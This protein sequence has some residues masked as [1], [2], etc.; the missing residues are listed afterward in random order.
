MGTINDTTSS[1]GAPSPPAV[2]RRSPP[3][4]AEA[5]LARRLPRYSNVPVVAGQPSRPSPEMPDQSCHPSRNA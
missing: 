3:V 2:R 1:A 5:R 4:D